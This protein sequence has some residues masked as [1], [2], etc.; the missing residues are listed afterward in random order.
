VDT[1]A[2]SPVVGIDVGENSVGLASII[3]DRDGMPVRIHRLSVVLH[4]SGKDG[5]ASGQSATVSRKASGGTARRIRRLFRNRRR[6]ALKLA[7]TLRGLG[8]PVISPESLG[9]YEEWET[10]I[11]LLEGPMTDITERRRALAIAIRHMSNHRGWANAWVPLD[12]YLWKEEPSQPFLAAVKAVVDEGR[13]GQVDPAS[14]RYQADLA[15]L[16]LSTHERLRPRKPSNP[17]PDAVT[18]SHLLGTQQRTDVV[19]EWRQI[20]RVQGASDEDFERLARV[21]FGQEKPGVPVENVG[22]DW[23]PGYKDKKRASVASLEHQ[24]FQIRQTVANLAI[25]DRPRSK[26][27]RRLTVDEQQPIVDTLM[28]ITSK[29][30]APAWK[31]L[32][33]DYLGINPV[34]LVHNDPEQSLSALAPVMRSVTA[35]YDGLP[36][37]HPV[38]RWWVEEADAEDR[39]AF[40]R[41]IADPV[42]VG[43]ETELSQK[44]GPMLEALDEKETDALQK[45]KFP[46]GRS[47]HSLEALRKLNAELEATGDTVD[48][49]TDRLFGSGDGKRLV[50]T[51]IA[52][53]DTEADHPTLQRVLP[54]VRRFL[55]AVDRE[56]G[57]PTRVVVEHVR[58]AFLGFTAKREEAMRQGRNRKDREHVQQDIAAAGLGIDN[59]SDSVIRKFQAMRRQNS[60]CLYCGTTLK[61][62]DTQL[63]HIVPR[64][65]GGNSTRA[66]LVA[67]CT[68][69]NAAKG[70]QPFARFAASGKR[71]GITLEAALDRVNTLDR[72]DLDW[73]VFRHMKA[74][75]SRRLKQNEEEDPVDER[76]LASTAYA[77]VDMRDRIDSTFGDNITKVYSGKI[78]SIARKASGIDKRIRIRDGVDTKSRFDRRHHAIDAAVA[79]MLNPSVARTLAERDDMV[80]FAKSGSGGDEWKTYEGSSLAAV[81]KFRSWKQAMEKLAELV[82]EELRRDR[83]AVVS[84]IR[85][86]AHHAALHEDGRKPHQVRRVSDVWPSEARARIVD[87]RVYAALSAGARPSEDLPADSERA[88]TLP[89]GIRLGADGEVFLFPDGRARVA[90]PNKSSAELGQSIHHIRLYR[91]DDARG[92]RRAGVVRLFSSDLYELTDGI[93]GDLLRSPLGETSRA[94]RR[95]NSRLRDA[96]HAGAAEHVGTFVPGDEVFIEPDEW[97][98]DGNE[99]ARFLGEL[100]E[101]HWRIVGW[102]EDGRCALNP[103]YLASEGIGTGSDGGERDGRKVYVSDHAKKVI[104]DRVRTSASSMWS[105]RSTLVVRRTGTGEV[106]AITAA[107]VPASWS[108]YEA[109][110]GE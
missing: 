63:D 3:C 89:S 96:L 14:L 105:K 75:M 18:T 26:A 35:L 32:A 31:Q 76:A 72:G 83:V 93:K 37:K 109:V 65:T 110:F 9:T 46:S 64:A 73:R 68:E 53:L 30:D 25:R 59:A 79:A 27:R 87:A 10:R 82:E 71:P 74:E 101:R 77:A 11:R 52:S 106:R 102:P 20:C 39:S 107:G 70:K 103:L 40:I 17:G 23:L 1:A 97:I 98:G 81:E 42:K 49:A 22:N 2:T 92:R 56:A 6:R 57:R 86:S 85:V 62:A 60:E 54:A 48:K 80:R 47:A 43:N 15:G 8:Y 58:D 51:D 90:L 108:P 33:E 50:P 99:L 104:E 55:L 67:V 16:G 41:W 34:L 94:V 28:S 19:R 61:F 7:D 91:W 100:P 84:P 36:K 45:L 44:F 69:C 29:D 38:L 5:M 4:D 78:V 95:S 21:A 66:N 88:I 12:V 24:E 13:F